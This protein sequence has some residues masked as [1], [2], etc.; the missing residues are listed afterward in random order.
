MRIQ[1]W[2]VVVAIFWAGTARAQAPRSEAPK[3]GDH[4][5][6]LYAAI[7]LEGKR[8]LVEVNP[9]GTW[10]HFPRPYPSI[11]ARHPF[12]PEIVEPR[13]VA[14]KPKRRRGSQVVARPATEKRPA[15]PMDNQVR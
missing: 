14:T 5:L 11:R 4:L 3:P 12:P 13:T 8:I 15:P 10:S 6:F 2:I 9:D 1:A 7:T